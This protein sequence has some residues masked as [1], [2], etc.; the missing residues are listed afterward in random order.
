MNVSCSLGLV[1]RFQHSKCSVNISERV[2]GRSVNPQA[3]V[4]AST[5]GVGKSSGR[6]GLRAQPLIS[7]EFGIR[8]SAKWSGGS[9]EGRSLCLGGQVIE[10]RDQ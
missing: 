2:E 1:Q 10:I 8:R 6:D 7:S 9:A 3:L 5:A 4:L